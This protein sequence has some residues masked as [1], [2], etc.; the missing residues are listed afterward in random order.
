MVSL[1]LVVLL[2]SLSVASMVSVMSISKQS[3]T[4]ETPLQADR[5]QFA[6][7]NCSLAMSAKMEAS[8]LF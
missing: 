5:R 1:V 2:M 7:G 8:F 4:A 6:T 3:E